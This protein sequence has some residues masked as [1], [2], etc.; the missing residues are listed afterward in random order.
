MWNIIFG[1]RYSFRLTGD[2]SSVLRYIGII[3]GLRILLLAMI[4]NGISIVTVS[5]LAQS[6]WVSATDF[7]QSQTYI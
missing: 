4:L 7:K 2:L 3:Y 1:S 5:M 6:V